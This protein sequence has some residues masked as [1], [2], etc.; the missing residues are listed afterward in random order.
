VLGLSGSLQLLLNCI[1]FGAAC[2]ISRQ[3]SGVSQALQY[4]MH[5]SLPQ[6]FRECLVHARLPWVLNG[7]CLLL[8]CVEI[9]CTGRCHLPPLHQ[10]VDFM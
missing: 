4:H 9:Q 2:K 3:S 7:T 5:G 10:V 8:L 1:A 6:E